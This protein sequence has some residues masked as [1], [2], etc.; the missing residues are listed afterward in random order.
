MKVWVSRLC[1]EFGGFGLG[2]N[3][4]KL[5]CGF[6]PFLVISGLGVRDEGCWVQ[7]LLLAA[8]LVHQTLGT[9]PPPPPPP[10][11][12]T[13]YIRGPIKGYL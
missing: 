4:S 10:P 1:G 7:L 11:P 5:Y 8:L 13:V 3:G 9:A 12:V 6:C 2:V